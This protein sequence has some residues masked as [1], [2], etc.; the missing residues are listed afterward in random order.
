MCRY[1]CL[2][3]ETSHPSHPG[4]KG[5]NESAGQ[6]LGLWFL[7]N[8]FESPEVLAANCPVNEPEM[9]Q[10]DLQLR[11]GHGVLRLLFHGAEYAK[12][13]TVF[14]LFIQAPSLN[15]REPASM[16]RVFQKSQ[17]LNRIIHP[18]RAILLFSWQCIICLS[19]YL[20][21]SYNI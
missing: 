17:L 6:N 11:Q 16:A 8:A 13:L 15:C 20:G 9:K 12:E 18:S 3:S 2:S 10:W 21:H 7:W 4:T 1:P 14:K 19:Y 5:L